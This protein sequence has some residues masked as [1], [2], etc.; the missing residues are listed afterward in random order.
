MNQVQIRNFCIIAH[1]EQ[2]IR[3]PFAVS[4]RAGQKVR[5]LRGLFSGE[6]NAAK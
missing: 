2:N 3:N 4:Y 6:Q 5:F 1:I